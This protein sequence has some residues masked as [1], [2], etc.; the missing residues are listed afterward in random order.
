[1]TSAISEIQQPQNKVILNTVNCFIKAIWNNYSI[2]NIRVYMMHSET[3]YT[4]L[5][6]CLSS[7]VKVYG[8]AIN[9]TGGT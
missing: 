3:P 9:N 7:V 5:Q 6:F 2:Q 1:V 8:C 4:A